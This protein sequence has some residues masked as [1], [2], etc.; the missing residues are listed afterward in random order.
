MW[1]KHFESLLSK[2]KEVERKLTTPRINHETPPLLSERKREEV[3]RLYW[4]HTRVISREEV[5]RAVRRLKNHKATYLD[6]IPNEALALLHRAQPHLLET[7]FNKIHGSGI[8]PSVWSKAYLKP[9]F[10]KGDKTDPANYRG[11][12]ISS[13][14]GKFFNSTKQ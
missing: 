3:K 12:A 11:I 4:E 8:F 14:L 9:L 7:L 5:D 6:S 13:C 1:V 10:K 2:K